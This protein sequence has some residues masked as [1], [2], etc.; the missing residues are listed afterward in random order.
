MTHVEDFPGVAHNTH[1]SLAVFFLSKCLQ[2]HLNNLLITKS[3]HREN[4]IPLQSFEGTIPH[5]LS[6]TI[7]TFEREAENYV[8]I[9]PLGIRH[10]Q[11]PLAS[12]FVNLSEF[13][14]PC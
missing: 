2:F 13:H 3:R 9:R 5:F 1:V 4:I 8:S 7:F 12:T 11:Q 10:L 6:S 14:D